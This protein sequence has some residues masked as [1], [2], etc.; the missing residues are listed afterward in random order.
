MGVRVLATIMPLAAAAGTPM[1][2]IQLSQHEYNDV[3][4]HDVGPG[5]DDLRALMAGP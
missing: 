4:G 1:P 3:M 2:G 5:N